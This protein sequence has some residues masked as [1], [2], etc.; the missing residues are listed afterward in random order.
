MFRLTPVG[1][2]DDQDGK[3]AIAFGELLISITAP[4]VQRRGAAAIKWN[5]PGPEGE[6]FDITAVQVSDGA[7]WERL[8]LRVLGDGVSV[9]HPS[10]RGRFC[11]VGIRVPAGAS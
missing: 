3:V 1:S 11:V 5:I 10:G 9:G 8:D 2:G 6:L 7:R 4:P